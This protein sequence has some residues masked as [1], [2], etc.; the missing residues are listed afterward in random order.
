MTQAIKGNE[1]H[2][3]VL[4]LTLLLSV[5]SNWLGIGNVTQTSLIKPKLSACPKLCKAITP[6]NKEGSHLIACR[7]VFLLGK[8]AQQ[9]DQR[10][11]GIYVCFVKSL[12]ENQR[13]TC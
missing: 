3:Y 10:K 12:M 5:I 7:L 13:L 4:H 1:S 9:G 2:A 8:L 11:T 6:L